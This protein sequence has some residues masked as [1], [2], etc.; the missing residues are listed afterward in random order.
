MLY[1]FRLRALLR[2]G[3]DDQQA[4]PFILADQ[5]SDSLNEQSMP[6]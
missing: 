4:N 5:G 2:I 3:A 6:S 1:R